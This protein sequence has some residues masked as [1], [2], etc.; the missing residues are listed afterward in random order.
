MKKVLLY[1]GS[2]NPVHNGHIALAE[3]AVE[4]ELCDEV[5]LIVS[6]QNPLKAQYELVADFARFEMVEMACS[7]S[8]Y[9]ERI[10][11]SAIEFA[12]ERPSYTIDTLRYLTESVGDQMELSILMGEDLILEIE[13]WKDYTEIL[14]KYPIFV[15]PRGEQRASDEILERVTYLADAPKLAISSTLM[16]AEIE[17]GMNNLEDKMN[18]GVLRYIRLNGLW[19]PASYVIALTAQIELTPDN[20]ELY[21]ERGKRYY[22]HNEWGRAINDFNKALVLDA[23]YE[24]A[25]Q[26]LGMAQEILTYRYTDIYNP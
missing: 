3:Y 6:P 4:R 25:R 19:T 14:D 16:R 13:R 11:T 18:K 1:F 20:A 15:Y 26:F 22:Q 9:P 24:E 12:L 21:L 2:F 10:K 8:K 7:A 23:D 5:V 17:K